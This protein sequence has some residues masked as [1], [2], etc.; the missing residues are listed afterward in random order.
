MLRRGLWGSQILGDSVVK[1]RIILK[2]WPLG[3]RDLQFQS[4]PCPPN[5]STCDLHTGHFPGTATSLS[6]P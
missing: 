3:R 2:T 5:L 4:P 6:R 1:K